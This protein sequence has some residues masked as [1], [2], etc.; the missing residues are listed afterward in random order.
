MTPHAGTATI[1]TGLHAGAASCDDRVTRPRMD[2]AA[3]APTA[4]SVTDASD[5]ETVRRLRVGWFGGEPSRHWLTRFVVLR[6]LG[7]S[8]TIAFLVLV[9]QRAGLIGSHGLAPAAVHLDRLRAH[10]PFWK[11]VTLFWFDASD[12]VLAVASWVG[13]ALALAVLAGAE[14]ALVMFALWL[15]YTSFEHVG[16]IFWGYGWEILLLE[17]GF[18]G[19]FLC[20]PRS[21]L[22]LRDP[23][24]APVLVVWMLRWLVF[25]VMFGAGLIK[26]RGDPCWTELTCLAFHYETQPN[27]NP[28]AWL[29]HQAPLWF[30]KTGVAFNHLVELVC[31]FLVFGPRY[32]RH[33]GGGLIVLFQV[34]LIL[35][36]NLSFLNWLTIGVAFAC[37]DDG[38]WARVLPRRLV[39][40]VDALER[41]KRT[42]RPRTVVAGV[43]AAVVAV[44]SVGPIGNMLSRRQQM[45]ASFDPLHLVNTYGAFGSVGRERFEVIVEGTDAA[46]PGPG[47]HWREY[48]FEC[49]PGDV[50]RRPCVISPYHYRLDWQMWFA[51]LPGHQNEPWFLHFVYKLLTGERAVLDLL[52]RNPFPSGPP[53]FVRAQLYRYRFTRIGERAHGW[54]QREYVRGYLPPVSKMHPQLR[55]IL[56]DQG[57]LSRDERNQVTTVSAR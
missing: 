51:A 7:L 52:D 3:N 45:N 49:K 30:H 48:E 14:N 19:I 15:L 53:R 12:T 43:L 20:P 46:T 38:L 16:Q 11:M 33:V 50:A 32:A 24:P 2:D 31:P 4:P 41:A 9:N 18:L 57:W 39:A 10:V 28:L 8:Y 27:P 34:I 54:W 44:L 35:S 22:P 26:L 47:A 56:A 1:R 21:L 17:A 23:V 25:R 13:L 5:G 29:L 55:A 6:A 37:F 36:G 40:R 42:S